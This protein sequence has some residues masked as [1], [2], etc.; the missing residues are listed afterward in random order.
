LWMG[1]EMGWGAP[2]V[3]LLGAAVFLRGY[4][5]LPGNAEFPIRWALV[6]GLT[7][8]VLHGFV[9]VSG[10]RMGTLWPVL[11]VA[12][13]L[14]GPRGQVLSKVPGLFRAASLPVAA[15]VIYW[16]LSI[17]GVHGLPTSVTAA[18][19]AQERNRQ[20]QA[21]EWAQVLNWS[22]RLAP[23]S[24]IDWE[25]RYARGMA[26]LHLADDLILAGA[27]L[28]AARKLEPNSIRT[29]LDEGWGWLP[30]QPSEAYLAWQ[31]A[32]RRAGDQR[33]WVFVEIA[34]YARQDPLVAWMLVP[35]ANQAPDLWMVALESAPASGIDGMIAQVL[36]E[37]ANVH[38]SAPAE[39][40]RI[41]EIWH[42]RADR[43]ELRKFLNAQPGWASE[44]RRYLAFLEA[45]QGQWEA[46]SRRAEEY[47]ASQMG[48]DDRR[49]TETVVITAHGEGNLVSVL[50]GNARK[51]MQLGQWELAWQVWNI[52]LGPLETKN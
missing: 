52:C 12:A 43:E 28:L 17:A 4:R 15:W 41:L 19:L 16:S 33:A 51:W 49:S 6:V 14:A 1:I 35:L 25:N 2:I 44:G 42:R 18:R 27:D 40:N 38:D 11:L 5:P 29:V 48:S 20:F 34:A 26:R 7:L 9:D 37:S 31:E 3:V 30:V 39:K 10:H 50:A 46:A 32:L 47:W 21:G 45:E 13:L 24:S 23:W 8:F 22:S 36:A